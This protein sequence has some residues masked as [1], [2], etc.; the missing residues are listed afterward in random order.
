MNTTCGKC[1]GPTEAGVTT[2]LGLIGEAVADRSEPRLAFVA[3]GTPTSA[4]LLKAVAQGMA[5]ERADAGYLIRARR[6]TRCG[7]VELYATESVTV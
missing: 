5:G 4:N 6:C 7:F 1:G 2:A 3:P